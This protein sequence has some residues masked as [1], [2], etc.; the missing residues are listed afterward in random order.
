M[1]KENTKP[2]SL[3]RAWR[4]YFASVVFLFALLVV[5]ANLNA[6]DG[7]IFGVLLLFYSILALKLNFN[8]LE[9]INFKGAIGLILITAFFWLLMYPILFFRLANQKRILNKDSNNDQI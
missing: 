9:K 2:M 3:M 6:S 4:Y 7:T 1:N 8:V 5:L